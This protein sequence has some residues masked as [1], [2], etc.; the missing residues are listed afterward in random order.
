M[1][2]SKKY[3]SLSLTLA[4]SLAAIFAQAQ[5]INRSFNF[6]VGDE[7]IKHTQITSSGVVER[8][9]QKLEVNTVADVKKSFVVTDSTESGYGFKI[10]IVDM[11]NQ[12]ETMGQKIHFDSK[13]PFDNT[14]RI[15][16]ALRFMVDKPVQLR[17]DRTGI[18]LSAEDPTLV[19]ANDSLLAFAG[20]QP[21]FFERGDLLTIVGDFVYNPVLTKGYSW[22][23]SVVIDEQKMVTDFIIEEITEGTTIIK[24]TSASYGRLINSNTNATYV[25][26]NKTGVITEKLIYT[27]STGFRVANRV[28]YAIS[29]S[30]SITERLT[31][32]PAGLPPATAARR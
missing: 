12:I 14:S 27:V 18:I 31:K 20:I 26:E 13:K 11:D 30:S 5:V 21:E 16:T 32:K 23:D 7:Y 22:T 10:T 3:L 1:N 29:R 4:L 8:G 2:L 15:E 6:K 24:L 9:N 28:L 25:V 19:L 17:T